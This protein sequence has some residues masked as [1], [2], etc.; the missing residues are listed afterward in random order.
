MEPCEEKSP[1]R[2]RAATGGGQAGQSV[3]LSHCRQ[4]LELG[5]EIGLVSRL[6][7][8]VDKG[9][10]LLA[11][12]VGEGV[13]GQ[14]VWSL[15]ISSKRRSFPSTCSIGSGRLPRNI[16]PQ[17][18]S[19]R[20][21][22]LSFPSNSPG[23][24]RPRHGN[25]ANRCIRILHG[26]QA[27]RLERGFCMDDGF[28]SPRLRA[29]EAST[30]STPDSGGFAF[31]NKTHEWLLFQLACTVHVCVET[32]LATLL[33]SGVTIHAVEENPGR[34]AGVVELSLSV[35]IGVFEC[36]ERKHGDE[37]DDEGRLPCRRVRSAGEEERAGERVRGQTNSDEITNLKLASNQ[38]VMTNDK[39]I[40]RRLTHPLGFCEDANVKT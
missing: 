38:P 24:R 26:I 28:S 40:G 4:H 19:Q 25:A 31:Q 15:S 23:S 35:F 16:S 18:F 12:P 9:V 27:G 5:A 33:A 37:L 17:R 34:G 2:F 10:D 36:E 29:P 32:S 14:G 3:D 7:G 1:K 39:Q 30:P 8:T 6:H 20:L 13:E 11:L 22:N 21:R